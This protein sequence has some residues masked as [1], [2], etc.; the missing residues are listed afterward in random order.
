MSIGAMDLTPLLYVVRA[1]EGSSFLLIGVLFS[2]IAVSSM[3]ILISS[4]RGVDVLII[5]SSWW[6]LASRLEK[7]SPGFR[8]F[9]AYISNCEQIGHCFELLHRYLFHG[10]GIADAISEGVNN[11]DVLDVRD[12][13]SGI[14][15]TLDIITGTL[16]VLLLNGLEGLG[17]RWTLIVPW[18]FLM[19]MAHSWSQEWIDPSGKLMSHDLAAPDNAVGRTFAFTW[20]SPPTASMTV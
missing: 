8:S 20:S 3:V 15:E 12:A 11:V 6:P 4:F 5:P 10:L 18:K 9:Y 17:G 13:V 7:L 19:N 2:T 16:V 1:S 14:A